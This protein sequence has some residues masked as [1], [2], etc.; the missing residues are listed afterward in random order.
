MLT[1]LKLD[2]FKLFTDEATVRFRPITV[3][4]GGN[5]T[6][7]TA[8]IDFLSL[9]GQTPENSPYQFPH[10]EKTF[11][12]GINRG[13]YQEPF[14]NMQPSGS[15][16]QAL[17]FSLTSRLPVALRSNGTNRPWYCRAVAAADYC[18]DSSGGLVKYA[19]L[20][21]AGQEVLRLPA[22]VTP[23]WCDPIP[24]TAPERQ[25][26]SAAARFPNPE[27]ECHQ[28]LKR[29]HFLRA[30][31][32]HP[33]TAVAAKPRTTDQM[34]RNGGDAIH[35]LK[36]IHNGQDDAWNFL[37]PQLAAIANI[38]ELKFRPTDRFVN[39]TENGPEYN[40]ARA[41]VRAR[42][43]GPETDLSAL[44]HGTA[45][46]VSI[47]TAGAV[48]E[49]EATL[50][51]EHPET[52]LDPATELAM[53][54]YFADLWR[55]RQV[56]SIIETHSDKLLLRLRRLVAIGKLNPEDLAVACFTVDPENGNSPMVK[57]L[58]VNP[59]GSL[60]PGLPMAFFGA[61]LIE[62]LAMNAGK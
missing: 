27:R 30:H 60:S 20:N 38:A 62:G 25:L 21:R 35:H 7:K 59:D 26:A 15:T 52:G 44:G 6:G 34:S 49:P 22:A 39:Y 43:G 31:R 58:E 16:N 13:T 10:H 41:F 48:L 45:N 19:L 17:R 54:Q 4:I 46:A 11:L 33:A 3:F 14:A 24:A 47:L 51:V 37:A 57:N 42:P 12:N 5:N 50:V 18:P 55:E 32:E 9:L 53:G 61:D 29:L 23:R 36:A 1:E 2:N 28:E 56:G 8:V 40:C